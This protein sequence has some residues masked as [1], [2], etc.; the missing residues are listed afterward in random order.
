MAKFNFA[1]LA[2]H[3]RGVDNYLAD[4]LSRNNRA[5][6]LT[7]HPQVQPSPVPIPGKLMELLILSAPDCTSQLRTK[8]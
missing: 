2:T 3:I 5:Y 4:A 1:V 6:F 7:N 8:L